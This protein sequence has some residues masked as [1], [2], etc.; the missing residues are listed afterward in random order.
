MPA[1]AADTTVQRTTTNV[2][3]LRGNKGAT[4]LRPVPR[5]STGKLGE[6]QILPSVTLFLKFII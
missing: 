3:N 5:T 6:F 2:D 4:K 1:K